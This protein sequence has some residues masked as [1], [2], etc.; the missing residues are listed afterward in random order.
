MPVMAPTTSTVTATTAPIAAAP[1]ASFT[2]SAGKAQH[3]EHAQQPRIEPDR[4][5]QDDV[6][7][8]DNCEGESGKAEPGDERNADRTASS[9][10]RGTTAPAAAPPDGTVGGTVGSAHDGAVWY[11]PVSYR[12]LHVTSSFPRHPDDPVAPFLLD[13]TRAQVDDGMAV[14]VVAPHD[15]GLP[16]REHFGAVEVV[17]ARYAPDGYER[18]AYRGGLLASARD[19]RVAPLVP[20]LVGALAATVR[21]VARDFR[22][23]VVHAHWWMP[24]GLAALAARPVPFVITL[25]GSD[26]GLAARPVAGP[27]GRAITARAKYVA[28]VSQP[29]LEE[30]RVVLRLDPSRSGVVRMPI[31]VDSTGASSPLAGPPWRLIAVGRASPEKGF[32]VLL[33]AM[34]LARDRG[35]D[36]RLEVIG[37]GPERRSLEEQRARLH[38]EDLVSFVDPLPRAELHARISSAH[39]LVVPSRREGLGLVAVEALALDRPVI[40][41]R[42]GGLEEVVSA[43]TGVLVAPGD[44][45][46]LASALCSMP[47]PGPPRPAP[48][49]AHH[50]IDAVVAAHRAMYARRDR[51]FVAGSTSESG[52][53][54]RTTRSASSP[55]AKTWKAANRISNVFVATRK[56]FPIRS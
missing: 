53:V 27:I 23:D 46:A 11:R 48:A 6:E 43:G 19:P 42:A 17:R 12:V 34:A 32:D 41:S 38:L 10:Q 28:A 21:R 30:A 4:D 54:T 20:G 3:A 44:A 13:L 47:M 51:Y 55:T 7:G 14:T 25:H 31:I 29:L 35:A 16:R 52:F 26:V 45:D 33:D 2:S 39:A 18:L 22:P 5:H 36:L 8:A 15:A 50:D 40:A 56:S 9:N 24:S 1:A 37:S 49:V